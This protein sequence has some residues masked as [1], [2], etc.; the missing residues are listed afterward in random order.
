MQDGS[1]LLLGTFCCNLILFAT[2]S[3]DAGFPIATL[4]VTLVE[5]YGDT[6]QELPP[7]DNVLVLPFWNPKFVMGCF[8]CL[9]HSLVC[10]VYRVP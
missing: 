6:K 4:S 7:Y 1:G 5:E 10:V 3:Q 2:S 8:C 9:Q